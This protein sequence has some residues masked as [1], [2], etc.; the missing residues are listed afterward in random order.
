MERKKK[1]REENVKMKKKCA[2]MHYRRRSKW[3]FDAPVRSLHFADAN[4]SIRRCI[5]L[6]PLRK[7]ICD[8]RHMRNRKWQKSFVPSRNLAS[9]FCHRCRRRIDVYVQ[10]PEIKENIFEPKTMRRFHLYIL[11]TQHKYMTRF[12]IGSNE[13]NLYIYLPQQLIFI[14]FHWYEHW[15]VNTCPNTYLCS[16]FGI[17]MCRRWIFLNFQT[18]KKPPSKTLE[19]KWLKGKCAHKSRCEIHFIC[20]APSTIWF[21]HIY[22]LCWLSA[23]CRWIMHQ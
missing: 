3:Y 9:H 2:Q 18:E 10:W 13:S 17:F 5:F 16:V 11:K 12:R 20:I 8:V 6:L 14:P 19:W 4:S 22:L 21:V 23:C 15:T 1:W 7:T